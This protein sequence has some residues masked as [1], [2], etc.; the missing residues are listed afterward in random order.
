M[1]LIPHADVIQERLD[2]LPSVTF[3]AGRTV[4]VA[5]S[6]TDQ[7]LFLKKGS[8]VVMKDGAEIAKVSQPRAVFGEIAVLLN[9]PHSAD[10][11]ALETSQFH[12]AD[13][14]VLANDS[15]ILMYVSAVL[16]Q[17]LNAAN[18]SLIELRMQLQ[19][20][21]AGGT[22]TKAIETIESLLSPSYDTARAL[23]TS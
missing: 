5:G 8:V 2:A 1:P 17:R 4:L 9:Q 19:D 23:L 13:P 11:R 12:V 14:D 20:G 7:L 3:E 6:R 10:V 15:F 21:Q 16:A 22:V 18:R